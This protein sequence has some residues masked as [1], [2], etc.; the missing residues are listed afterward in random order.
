MTVLAIAL[1]IIGG[2][3]LTVAAI[4]S[5][6]DYK[7]TG[8]LYRNKKVIF[9]VLLISFAIFAVGFFLAPAVE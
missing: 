1:L 5:L 7:R 9:P 6:I 4:Y 3:S 2:G 8:V